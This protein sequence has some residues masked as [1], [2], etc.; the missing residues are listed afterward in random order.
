[1]TASLFDSSGEAALSEE[2]DQIKQS[3][4][5]NRQIDYTQTFQVVSSKIIPVLGHFQAPQLIWNLINYITKLLEKASENQTVMLECFKS[6]NLLHLLSLNSQL[7]DEAIIDMMKNL[8]VIQQDSQVILE[9]C[10]S[11]IDFKLS[12]KLEPALI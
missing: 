7:I 1:M 9:M 3:L 4:A 5:I 11:I 12:K 2:E 10:V 6:M 8:F